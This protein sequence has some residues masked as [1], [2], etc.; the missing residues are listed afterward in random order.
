MNMTL[1]VRRPSKREI[2]DV[3]TA[4]GVMFGSPTIQQP[5]LPFG[6]NP[7]RGGPKNVSRTPLCN[8]FGRQIKNRLFPVRI[9]EP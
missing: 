8:R 5:R 2:R 3:R 1:S 9:L 4:L 7:T 6:E